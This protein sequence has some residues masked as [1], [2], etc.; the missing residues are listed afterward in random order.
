MSATSKPLLAASIGLA[1]TL[2]PT[3]GR[4]ATDFG[5]VAVYVAHMLENHHYSHLE[6]D[7]DMSAKMLQNYL[8]LLDPRHIFFTQADVD[9]FRKEYK[10]T[11]DDHITLRDISPAHEIYDLYKQRVRDRVSFVKK[12]L[13]TKKFT[14]ESDRT[15]DLKR[16]KLPWPADAAASDALWTDQVENDLL[17]ERMLD[18]A[19]EKADAEKAAKAAEKKAK[20]KPDEAKAE[21]KNAGAAPKNEPEKKKETPEQ[22]VAKYYERIVESLDENDRE[23][24]VDFFL[25]SL[26]SAYDPHTDYM[27]TREMENFDIQMKHQLVGIGAMLG[28]DET[29]EVAVIQGIVVG[30]PADKQGELKLN[31]KI[32]AVA[33][34][35]ADYVET[36]SLK[37]QRIVEMIRGDKGTTV[38]LKIIPAED[39]STVKEISI[40][41]AEVELK[42]KLANAE[43]LETPADLGAPSKIGWIYL[44]SFYADMDGGQVST[45]ADVEKLLRRLMQEKIDGLVLD[46]RG[47]RG[48]SLEEAIKLTG[49]FIPSGPVVQIKDHQGEITFRECTNPKAEYEGPM[50]VLTDKESASASEILAAAL[51]DYRRAV[52]V[53]DKSTFGKGTV[54]TILPV[55]R[56]M[57][58]FSDKSRAGSLKVTIQ[59]FYRIAGGSTQLRGVVPDLQIPSLRDVMD[60]GEGS[61]ENAL[62]YDEIPVVPYTPWKPSPLPL[63]E[64]A[65]RMTSRIKANSDF[66]YVQEESKRLK[67]RIERQTVS[68]SEA[69]RESEREANEKRRNAYEEE[70]DKRTA[71]VR[72]RVKQNGFKVYHI[73]VDNASQPELVSHEKFTSEMRNGMR[74]AKSDDEGVG[75]ESEFPYGMEPTKLETVHILRDLIGMGKGQPATA[76]ASK[77]TE[78][79]KPSKN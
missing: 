45:T 23:D 78:S 55:E 65:A 77:S 6:F 47:N 10:D 43:L 63:K 17:Q 27:S 9:R 26:S 14:F 57:P 34:G 51:Q 20:A 32:V 12:T 59:K 8:D 68:L 46:L 15:L 69:K 41:R 49:L 30:G 58:F 39:E 25:S 76:E 70:R 61:T 28:I 11:L 44:N 74:M 2:S 33:Q 72:E 7:N 48:G 66:L 67:E 40:V 21:D 73:T 36:R 13:E 1:L 5:Q 56:Y 75:E 79:E 3:V 62:P 29:T 64:L 22:R 38:R 31:D 52:I 53:G 50:I 71:A 4:S 54:Q 19:R 24:V 18:K 60:F 37:L 35:N 16:E 42:D